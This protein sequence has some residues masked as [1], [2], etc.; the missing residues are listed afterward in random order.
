MPTI[1]Q[2]LC[3]SCFK[4]IKCET[5]AYIKKEEKTEKE[6]EQCLGAQR[7]LISISLDIAA[8]KEAETN[9]SR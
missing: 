9:S 5:P 3:R 8:G 7:I 6:Y 2:E 1:F 4:C